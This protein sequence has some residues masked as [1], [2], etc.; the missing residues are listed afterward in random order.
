MK[1]TARTGGVRQRDSTLA[2]YH[3]K[4]DF[5]RTPEPRGAVPPKRS[6]SLFVI[7]KHDATRLHYDFRLEIG[8]VLKS[9]AIPRGPSLDPADKRLAMRTEDHPVEYGSFEGT[10]PKGEYGGGPVLLWDRGTWTPVGDPAAGLRSGELK[11]ILEGEK[12]HGGW[13]LIR[14][15][16]RTKR[17]REGRTWLLVKERDRYAKRAGAS[18]ITDTRP[19]SVVSGRRLEQIAEA[20]APSEPTASPVPRARHNGA[21]APS[22]PRSAVKSKTAPLSATRPARLPRFVEPELATLV[23][24]PPDGDG[25]LHEMKFDGYR[26][27]CRIEKGRATLWSRNA[28]DW[29][30]RFPAVA[31]AATKLP[32]RD[33]FLDGEVV[34][35]LP[36]GTTSFQAL[37]NELSAGTHGRLV[38]FVFDLLYLDGQD[39]TRLHLE[40]RKRS[41]QHLI[42]GKGTRTIRYSRHV[43]GQG[44][45]FFREACR[46]SLEGIVSKRRDSPYEPGRGRSWLKAKC[47]REQELVIGGFTEPQGTR[48]GLGALL[49]GVHDA[50]AGGLTYV[51][52]VGTGFT[53]DTARLLRARLDR[54]RAPASPFKHSPPGAA[55]AR[56]VKPELVAEVAFTEWTTDGR[57]RHPSFKGLREDKPAAQV[58]RERPVDRRS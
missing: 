6:S 54:L 24:A 33:A 27:L 37:Q 38:Y 52:K 29:T 19:E 21:V 5:A 9:W 10:I 49:L 26:I 4:R 14:I 3:A 41:L 7:Q 40:Q 12:L 51:G 11:F 18:S 44:A 36:N 35:L 25:W 23:S 47:V 46:R 55:A 17:D 16:G 2:L 28:H 58:I 1:T 45:K 20:P 53:D 13:A 57:L 50:H 34:V 8:G 31:A 39:L 56:W 22:R 30:S 42:G 48:V 32:A 43:M 15:R